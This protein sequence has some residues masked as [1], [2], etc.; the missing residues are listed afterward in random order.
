MA[1]NSLAQWLEWQ[2][3]LNPAEI[4]L[5][6]E[7]V[8]AVYAQLAI[9][10]PPGRVFTVAGTNGKGSCTAMLE[11]VLRAAGYTTGLYTSPHLS[12]YN[13]RI[14]MAGTVA[15]DADIVAA[16]ERVEAARGDV[17]LTY[18]EFGTLAALMCFAEHG[19]DAWVLEVGLGGRLDAVNVVDPDF[20]VITTVALDHQAW[21]GD[22]VEE[23]AAEKAGILRAG[24]P[25]FF[26]DSPVPASISAAAVATGAHLYCLEQDFA[27]TRGDM[28]WSWQGMGLRVENLQLPVPGTAAQLRNASVALAALGSFDPD[29]LARADWAYSLGD[30]LA[31]PGRFER[32]HDA[33]DWVL[34]VAHN[35]QAAET[36]RAGL[37]VLEPASVTLVV[38]MLATKATEAFLAILAPLA[39]RLITCD[40]DAA[41]GTP[42]ADLAAVFAGIAP[43]IPVVAS[44]TVAQ[45]LETARRTTPGGGRIVVCGS[46]HTVGPAR[47]WLGLY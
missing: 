2:E 30:Y 31:L 23:I 18:F 9:A 36:L 29:L 47:E 41:Q 33:H 15:T 19:C 4:D 10:P 6:L 1:R 43:H 8:A 22:T 11:R 20:A 26:G 28:A 3:S 40:L 24:K 46:F 34:D 7:R 37:E 14:Q 32:H 39:A 16:F 17:P 35:P 21:L 38:G 5:G 42:G 27:Y 44:P 12:R 25:A 45:A 13:E